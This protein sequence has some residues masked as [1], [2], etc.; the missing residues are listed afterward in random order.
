MRA[1][2]EGGPDVAGQF[3]LYPPTAPG[4]LGGEEPQSPTSAFLT[5]SEMEWYW[6][7]YLQSDAARANPLAVPVL[8]D[9]KDLPPTS[10][11]VAGLDPLHPEGLDLAHRLTEAGVEVSLRDYSDAVHGFMLFAADLSV[12]REAIREVGAAVRD[13]LDQHRDGDA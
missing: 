7:R 12:G 11:V 3:L 6:S 4:G 10:I 8:G 1:R 2:D 5:R 13:V 9:L